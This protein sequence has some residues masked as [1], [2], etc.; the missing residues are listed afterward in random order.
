MAADRARDRLNG[1]IS[2]QRHL[3]ISMSSGNLSHGV[4]LSYTGVPRMARVRQKEYGPPRVFAKSIAGF[5][6]A[7]QFSVIRAIESMTRPLT[8]W[9]ID[10]AAK[11]GAC[12][13]AARQEIEWPQG[14][15]RMME[16]M[17][18]P[19][20]IECAKVVMFSHPTNGESIHGKG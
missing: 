7:R 15:L 18:P 12:F 2:E 20:G 17:P 4:R 5:S 10:A 11:G 16:W 1:E 19:D 6:R 8:F 9:A 3:Y 14:G 13:A